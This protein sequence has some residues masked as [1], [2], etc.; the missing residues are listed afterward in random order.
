MNYLNVDATYTNNK[1]AF[2]KG[3]TLN[4]LTLESNTER[5]RLVFGDAYPEM[6]D[7]TLTHGIVGAYGRQDFE[8]TS[9]SA[10]AGYYALDKDDMRNPR[11]VG[12]FRLEHS[13]DE[14]FKI[15]FNFAGIDD[16]RDNA[17]ASLDDPM[18]YNRIF[19]L[20]MALKANDNIYANAE[21]ARSETD[22]DKRNS[23]GRINGDAYKLLGGFKKQ[24]YKIEFGV[25]NADSEFASPLG[26]TPRDEL[27]TFIRAY[28]DFN[29]Y[30]SGKAGYRSGRDN[31]S[32]YMV[33]TIKREQTEFQVTLKPSDYYENMRFDFYYLP[34]HEHSD[35]AGFMNRYKDMYWF[36]FNNQTGRMKYYAGV[37]QT[38]ERD[39]ITITNDNDLRRFDLSLTWEYDK[40]NKIYGSF[41]SESIRY[42]HADRNEKSQWFS[43]GG[44]SRFH[45]N[46]LF[47]FDY[48]REKIDPVTISSIHDRL[49]LSLTREYNKSTNLIIE[50]EGNISEYANDIASVEDY[51]AKLRL[52]KA[53]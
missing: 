3:F 20:D 46:I 27:S 17:A 8:Y 49:N 36:E 21:I 16:K 35:V 29:K 5:S 34:V 7:Y 11:Y 18:L 6:S 19:S 2:E 22:Y 26:E 47:S 32:N 30:V 4:N 52:Q 31:I 25:E 28:Y 37:S 9:V 24:N 45:Y 51:T 44:A 33:N 43:L 1:R 40:D 48:Q 42:K 39:D 12:G 41:G 50:F 10:F 53:F 23:A 13:K 38:I 14:S 15:G